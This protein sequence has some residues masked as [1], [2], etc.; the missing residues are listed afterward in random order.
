MGVGQFC[1]IPGLVIGLAGPDLDAFSAA[2]ALGDKVAGTMLS[3]G[4]H[5]AYLDAVERRSGLAGVELLAQGGAE[6]SGCAAR[7]ALYRTDA[8]TFLATPDLGKRTSGRPR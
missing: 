8:A 4:I 2:A 1:T 7:A 3:A 6:G 5:Q